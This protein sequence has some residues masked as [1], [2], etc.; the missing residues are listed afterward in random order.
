MNDRKQL[1]RQ[2]AEHILCY[3]DSEEGCYT[4]EKRHDFLTISQT[5]AQD[6]VSIWVTGS[7]RNACVFDEYDDTYSPGKW[8]DKLEALYQE[9]L[10]ASHDP[11]LDDLLSPREV[12]NETGLDENAL[13][14][15]I[16]RAA[17]DYIF[18][19][20]V[21]FSKKETTRLYWKLHTTHMR[22]GQLQL[23]LH[24]ANPKA[25]GKEI[26]GSWLDRQC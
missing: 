25:T 16:V 8:E 18:A 4:T 24:K 2:M 23:Q 19:V 3:L 15:D 12:G 5:H 26:R 14:D 11:V 17:D 1:I 9:S 20:I 10:E 13:K 7:V 22:L 21:G 6:E